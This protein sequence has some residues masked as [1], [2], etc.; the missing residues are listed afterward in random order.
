M[1]GR[2]DISRTHAAHVTILLNSR[3]A[4]AAGRA[5]ADAPPA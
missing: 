2:T 1:I 3:L 4:P 5:E